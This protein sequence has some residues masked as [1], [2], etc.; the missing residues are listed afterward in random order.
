MC[1]YVFTTV[2]HKN[3]VD[4]FRRAINR[5]NHDPKNVFAP[6][7]RRWHFIEIQIRILY[8]HNIFNAKNNADVR[9]LGTV[10]Y[11]C[12]VCDGLRISLI[13][14]RILKIALELA[15][16]R[17]NNAKGERAHTQNAITLFHRIRR[18]E[19]WLGRCRTQLN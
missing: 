8:A 19:K 6:F 11:G 14:S 13:V 2:L 16:V 15:L 3:F 1:V 5:A 4:T 9:H 7:A 18:K 12:I 10:V 17:A